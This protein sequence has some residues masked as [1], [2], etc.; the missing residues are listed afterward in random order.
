MNETE[1]A[2]DHWLLAYEA[3][4]HIKGW[5]PNI[6]TEDPVATHK[7]FGQLKAVRVSFYRVTASFDI[8]V[9]SADAEY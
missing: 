7:E 3:N 8:D 1:L 9:K 6:D 5:L 2:E 4:I